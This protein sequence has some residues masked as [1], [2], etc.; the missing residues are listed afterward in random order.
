MPAQPATTIAKG[1]IVTLLRQSATLTALVPLAS[2]HADQNPPDAFLP[3]VVAEVHDADTIWQNQKDTQEKLRLRVTVRAAAT[4]TPGARNPAEQIAD[5]VEGVL[6][7]ADLALAKTA[8][9]AFLKT[10]RVSTIEKRTS[11]LGARV[12]RTVIEWYIEYEQDS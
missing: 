9:L 4:T 6:N 1:A 2:I 5:A 12:Y 11:K 3:L 10:K 7:W 8:P